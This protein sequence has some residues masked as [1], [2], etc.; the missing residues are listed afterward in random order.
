[1]S[2]LRRFPLRHADHPNPSARPPGQLAMLGAPRPRSLKRNRISH[3]R[4]KASG[5]NRIEEALVPLRSALA[6]SPDAWFPWMTAPSPICGSATTKAFFF[7]R[8]RLPG[9]SAPGCSSPYEALGKGKAD[10]DLRRSSRPRPRVSGL[11]DS[12]ELDLETAARIR[13]AL[14]YRA[15]GVARWA[16]I[17]AWAGFPKCRSQPRSEKGLGE[18]HHYLGAHLRW[19]LD[20]SCHPTA[21]ASS[22]V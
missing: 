18:A 4:A 1:M 20:E 13:D 5:T 19:P 21:L 8:K 10:R 17:P 14:R 6:A 3:R 7:C 16:A 2:P 9:R 22:L 15:S 12:W 11:A